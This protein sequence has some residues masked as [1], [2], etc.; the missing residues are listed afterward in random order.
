MASLVRNIGPFDESVERFE[1]LFEHHCNANGLSRLPLPIKPTEHQQAEI[2]YFREVLNAPI[3]SVQN[4][5]FCGRRGEMT[6]CL[7]PYVVR[8]NKLTV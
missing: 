7:N 1:Y 4:V 5:V 2:F 6:K 8:R 3:P